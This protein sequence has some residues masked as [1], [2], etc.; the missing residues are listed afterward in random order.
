MLFDSSFYIFSFVFSV[1]IY[2]LFSYRIPYPYE[3]S[4]RYTGC[5]GK[6]TKKK[7]NN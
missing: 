6:N 4:I 3:L 7:K 5:L 1:F 2:L